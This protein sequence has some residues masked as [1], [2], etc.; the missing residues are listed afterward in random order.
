MVFLFKF[1]QKWLFWFYLFHSLTDI[2]FH[3]KKISNSLKVSPTFRWLLI[4]LMK[5]CI[6]KGTSFFRGFFTN[7][8]LLITFDFHMTVI[9]ATIKQQWQCSNYFTFR[10]TV[11]YFRSS[12]HQLF[13]VCSYCFFL[14]LFLTYLVYSYC[15][16]SS[17]F[18]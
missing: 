8:Y 15:W 14:L 10:N 18:F 5:R 4:F 13:K 1:L 11:Q 7:C 9:T 16:V 3:R 17:S 2:T 12:Q 6:K